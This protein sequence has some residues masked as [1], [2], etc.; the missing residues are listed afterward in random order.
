M[1]RTLI[2]LTLAAVVGAL[3]TAGTTLAREVDP[4]AVT[5]AAPQESPAADPAD[6]RSIDAIIGALYEAISGPAGEER[7]WDRLRSLFL[8]AARLMPNGPTPEGDIQRRVWT[9]EEYIDEVGPALVERGFYEDEVGRVTERY[10]ELAHAFSAYESRWTPEDPEPFQRGIN[11][12]QLL[13]DGER[14]W[15][16]N[17]AWRPETPETPIPER[18]LESPAG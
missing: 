11:S 14:W 16:A 9:V 2:A 3:H 7:D 1:P 17:I 4:P 10:G 13:Y 12:I 6:V 15:V 5:G 8:P 18:Y